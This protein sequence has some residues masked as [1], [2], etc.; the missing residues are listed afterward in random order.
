MLTLF[1]IP[2]Q[3][4][5]KIN[6]FISKFLN[7][8]S[9]VGQSVES[10]QWRASIKPEFTGITAVNNNTLRYDEL[11]I[12]LITLVNTDFLFE[13]T[14][15]IYK[16]IKYP[17]LLILNYQ[18]KFLVSTCQFNAGKVDKDNN[19]LHAVNFSH[20]IHADLLSPGADRMICE[21]NEAIN[22]K[23][24]LCHI[25][26]KMTHAIQNFRLGGTTKAHVD[27]LLYDMCGRISAAKRD[28][29]MKY[30]TPYKKHAP[31]DA[32]R[33]TKYNKA[34]RTSAYTYS[35]DYE[36]IWYCLMCCE[37]T[38]EVI[39]KRK[40]RDIEDLIYSIDSKSW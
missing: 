5:L 4:A 25:Y 19:L 24:D 10:I 39:R 13:V 22:E 17:C 23:S 18:N 40:Y 35:Y 20:W 29:I 16:E 38:Q 36:D 8:D 21:I 12:V 31:L 11:Q 15:K 33:A 9:D 2:E 6:V 27:R 7:P 14:R 3:C 28:A 37:E 30:C 1:K 26:T 32:S 34:K